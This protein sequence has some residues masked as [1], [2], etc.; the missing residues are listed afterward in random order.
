M[1]ER[2][3]QHL[4]VGA[5]SEALQRA[6]A[7]VRVAGLV[8]AQKALVVATLVR[9]LSR[10]FVCVC[11]DKEE[12]AYLL[13][14][15]QAL[16]GEADVC[17]FPDSF[18]RPAVFEHLNTT[19]TLQRSEVVNRLT[20]P[21]RWG[22]AIVTYPEALFEEV[23]APEVLTKSRIEIVKG[24]KLDIDFVIQ[25]LVEYGFV[26]T[27]FVYEPGQFS[28][29]GGILDL[30]SYGN[31]YP[32]RIEL[33]D[34]E[35]ESIRTF[36]P[37]TQLSRQN[38]ERVQIVPNWGTAHTR[39][40]KMPLLRVLPSDA[41]LWIEDAQ[42]LHDRLLVCFEEAERY[43][44]K[45]SALDPEEVRALLKE[46]AFVRPIDVSEALRSY[47]LVFSIPPTD[48]ALLEAFGLAPA[49]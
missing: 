9:Q 29:R 2:Y 7:R 45:L 44:A 47:A 40:E 31:E 43:A 6:G 3:A 1:L 30:F 22:W 17:F 5:L 28:L 15:L 21:H 37:L 35:V 27:D 16:M 36:D 18:R 10:L 11:N 24:E 23:V 25:V 32:Y 48:P 38:I 26:R 20:M 42:F 8:G 14:D 49:R 34:V 13:N 4:Q 46:R 33:L 19:Q 41:V 39:E 12:A